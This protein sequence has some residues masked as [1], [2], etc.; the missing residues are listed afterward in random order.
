LDSNG[1]E[2]DTEQNMIRDQQHPHN[3][4]DIGPY[5]QVG[6]ENES[7]ED[8][9]QT[10]CVEAPI[11]HQLDKGLAPMVTA[12]VL[13]EGVM[14]TGTPL[15]SG[16]CIN[17]MSEAMVTS[18][19]DEKG[20]PQN[21]RKKY[22]VQP[23]TLKI[24][25]VGGQIRNVARAVKLRVR[26]PN[27]QDHL[28]TFCVI[29]SSQTRILL[30]TPALQ[31]LGV[32]MSSPSRPQL[33]LIGHQSSDVFKP[34]KTQP[35][36]LVA[37][38]FTIVESNSTTT[39]KAHRLIP[40]TADGRLQGSDPSLVQCNHVDTRMCQFEPQTNIA[41]ITFQPMVMPDTKCDYLEVEAVNGC[42]QDIYVHKGELLGY[43]NNVS[44][45]E[46]N[47]HLQDAPVDDLIE[48][49]ELITTTDRIAFIRE[50]L[51]PFGAQ[52]CEEEK[53]RLLDLIF[54]NANLV[55]LGLNDLP[56]CSG[57]LME[58]DTGDS[59]PFNQG[60]RDEPVAS[61]QFMRKTINELE[62]YG[63]IARS[64]APY[65]SPV[66]VAPKKVE[67][68]KDPW[69][70]C[71]DARLLNKQT[72]PMA[73]RVPRVEEMVRGLRG[74]K[75]ISTLD[76][77]C[78][79]WQVGL[80]D[81]ASQKTTF[82]CSM[83]VFRWL[84]MPY[85]LRNAPAVYIAM[86]EDVLKELLD[87][88]GPGSGNEEMY[89]GVYLDDLI[90]ATA[91]I[92]QQFC[93]LNRIFEALAKAN[94]KL[95]IAKCAFC[96]TETLYLGWYVSGEGKRVN[97]K[98]TVAISMFPTPVN[99]T[100]V[101]RFLGV[102]NYY[103][104]CMPN[105][106]I[107]AAPLHDL[108]RPKHHFIWTT[109]CQEAFDKLKKLLQDDIMLLHPDPNK[110]FELFTDACDL[111]IAAVLEQKDDKGINR[112][113]GY[114]SRKL[115]GPHTRYS[116]NG[117]EALALISGIRY[118]RPYLIGT[119]VKVFTDHSAL[120][121]ILEAPRNTHRSDKWHEE[122]MG[123][124]VD[125]F[126]RRGKDN[127]NAD[128][129]S[130]YPIE[131]PA[132]EDITQ[133]HGDDYVRS[134]LKQ[135]VDIPTSFV[136]K[137][138]PAT[139]VESQL[140]EVSSVEESEDAAMPTVNQALLDHESIKMAQSKCKEV[141]KYKEEWLKD[142]KSHP[143]MVVH[144]DTLLCLDHIGVGYYVP[145]V[146]E[147][148]R[149]DVVNQ[150]HASPVSG[151]LHYPKL[152]ELIAK[153][154]GWPSMKADMIKWVN[155]CHVCIRSF[156]GNHMRPHLAPFVTER[157][158]QRVV[159][160]VAKVG[161]SLTG[162]THVVVFVDHYSKYP[163]VVPIPDQSAQTLFDAFITG[164]V[165]HHG[166]P[167]E[168]VGDAHASQM[169]DLFSNSCEG[170]GC[171]TNFSQGY[172]SRHAGLVE[173]M[174][175]TM[176]QMLRRS[177]ATEAIDWTVALPWTLLEYRETVCVATGYSP[178]FLVY[179]RD[180]RL[181]IDQILEFKPKGIVDQP[182]QI[183]QIATHLDHAMKNVAT[184]NS[185]W[186]LK[187]VASY[188]KQHKTKDSKVK[189]GD[190]VMVRDKRELRNREEGKLY[191]NQVTGPYMVD[192][193]DL[194]NIEISQ[195][196]GLKSRIV[197]LWDVYRARAEIEP[198]YG[199]KKDA[200]KPR[201]L[202]PPPTGRAVTRYNLR[203]SPP[204]VFMVTVDSGMSYYTPTVPMMASNPS[205]VPTVVL[206][207]PQPTQHVHQQGGVQYIALPPQS[208]QNTQGI[209]QYIP[210]P[211]QPTQDALY[212]QYLQRQTELH[213]QTMHAMQLHT[214]QMQMHS[215]QMEV[216]RPLQAV[217]PQ[218]PVGPMVSRA[219]DNVLARV[220]M[221]NVLDRMQMP[222][223]QR[224]TPRH[225]QAKRRADYERSSAL[226]DHRYRQVDEQRRA[227]DKQRPHYQNTSRNSYGQQQF[228]RGSNMRK[229]I[230][231]R[232]Q[233]K[234]RS[235]IRRSPMR[236]PPHSDQPSTSHAQQTKHTSAKHKGKGRQKKHQLSID[237]DA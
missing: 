199:D 74:K 155:K 192:R 8:L 39:V 33:N 34:Q 157:R 42:S 156:P 9:P 139:V 114:F 44:V 93:L 48:V 1:Y 51:K 102:C 104:A 133:R 166:V 26:F 119:R 235:P 6:Q 111:G 169:S 2:G 113:I 85:G 95:G 69:R 217:H 124:N 116:T 28:V 148:M 136:S 36:Q 17:V 89:F 45:Y 182:S 67:P 91:T 219:E 237:A 79:Y 131:E 80:T 181:P 198:F 209:A 234:H 163:I 186:R 125:M 142:S 193:I 4:L 100:D 18:V 233:H 207:P 147:H 37:A 35:A 58:I 118:F 172:T 77:S 149:K 228:R 211:P 134:K 185:E 145:F 212:S 72:K 123:Y 84:R 117:K 61:N 171:K 115:S 154:C 16:S 164:V 11:T 128:V 66:T 108:T 43:C 150:A 38:C 31:Q 59:P 49:P 221:P 170:I 78:A 158:F 121:P 109:A 135:A 82:T 27:C 98:Q 206:M 220:S 143:N 32:W 73:V 161:P 5:D 179:G 65:C 225:S 13:V 162:M 23:P 165:Q 187:M 127:V 130:R 70:M 232:D 151:H 200:N 126:Y 10:M 177:A 83:G 197:H 54:S 132:P 205:L 160:D 52:M 87:D 107:I 110:T 106:S 71:M 236:R 202:E 92:E 140:I 188:Q 40:R 129:L 62:K 21:E 230:Y 14:I 189:V 180:L 224:P 57:P 105:T 175:R 56:M 226:T 29:D 218:Y 60:R 63:M 216:V 53:E 137:A 138:K 194:P 191:V 103:R 64:K 231:G 122:I 19:F 167:D 203:P 55:S 214:Q 112:P 120:V 159:M 20:I 178:A 174:I 184:T 47:H 227:W 50:N 146:P 41:N 173:R 204:T 183:Q 25:V 7:S 90:C 223:T 144:E 30:G 152:F 15:D 22:E 176:L 76:L 210:L 97:P 101:R 12:R 24:Q 195:L 153:R 86:I 81:D 201:A 75:F 46:M 215:A 88:Y 141:K 222:P 168:M 3:L 94:L 229:A 213:N 68:P 208:T 196:D 190:R 99:V 96:V